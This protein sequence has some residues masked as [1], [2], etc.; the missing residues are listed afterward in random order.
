MAHPW[1][2]AEPL[3][4]ASRPFVGGG[5]SLPGPIQNLVASV[6]MHGD[7]R[8]VLWVSVVL[9]G[10]VGA[11]AAFFMTRDDEELLQVQPPVARHRLRERT[12]EVGGVRRPITDIRP[13]SRR[14]RADRVEPEP[15]NVGVAP[16]I[17][18]D[19]NPQVASVVEAIETG[20]HP[21]RL[22]ALIAPAP[23]DAAAFRADPEAY[24][25]VSEPG[26]VFQTAQPG[27]GV[28]RLAALVPRVADAEQ[29]QPV[30]L[31]VQAVAAAPVTFT[32]FDLGAFENQLTSITVQ[33]D[34]E[35][36]AEAVFTGTPGTY[37]AAN[38]LAA[39][40]MTAGQLR[41][42]VNVLPPRRP[43]GRQ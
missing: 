23:F 33:A 21:E 31:R 4:V 34:A 13:V 36:V 3:D 17:P 9:L 5:R 32:S 26:R 43:A 25:N 16:A 29:G 22:S 1:V 24:L 18:R 6:S 41:F 38:I 8:A 19:A 11:M 7:R 15:L 42:I 37:N 30:T 27:P 39:S 20:R 2:C 40:P 14:R 10:L 35:G 28:P 12:V